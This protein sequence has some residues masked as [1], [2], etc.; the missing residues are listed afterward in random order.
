MR[1]HVITRKKK[2]E[3]PGKHPFVVPVVVFLL[4]FFLSLAF[5]V[6]MGGQTIGANDRRIVRLF[7]DGQSQVVPTRAKTVQEL[8]TRLSIQVN[9]KDIVEPG[10]DTDITN[11]GFN[12]NVYRAR[13]VLVEDAGQK[14]QIVTAEPT[15]ERIAE[16]V[17]LTIYPED[18]VSKVAA[19]IVEPIQALKQGIVSERIVIDRATPVYLNLY[20]ES[21]AIR[22]HA[23]TIADLLSEKAIK[24]YEGDTL[25]PGSGTL[26]APNLQIFV[27]RQG[28]QVIIQ[29]K[30]IEAPVERQEDPAA[31]V[32]RTV[33]IEA[34]RPGKRVVTYEIDLAND[35]EV[36]RREIQSVIVEQ[37]VRRVI[38]VGTRKNSF[39][40]GF[41][42]ALAALRGCEAGGNYANKSNPRYRGAYQ[43]DY[44][45]WNNYG[46]YR[47]PAD[48]PPI[49]QD[50]KTAE[51]YQRRG[52]QPWPGCTAKLG[53]QDVY[54]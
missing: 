51:T 12:V 48:A 15:P 18:K 37:P 35:Q 26:I 34:G 16:K 30:V 36:A 5:I 39:S 20:G 45:T 54:R 47:D 4:L 49:V 31:D 23:I 50:Q 46:G 8:L 27:I 7:V 28:K 17:G 19:D 10:L 33:V 24:T 52:W 53:L 14:R 13:S 6:N 21:F 25:Q 9:E 29:E 43:F 41:E 2:T 40:G 1:L 3:S 32:G 44:S 38:K 22:T 11:N 42:T